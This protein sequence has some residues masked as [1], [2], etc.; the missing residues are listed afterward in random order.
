MGIGEGRVLVLGAALG[1]V[2]P[3]A[4]RGGGG[5]AGSG[6]GGILNGEQWGE[7]WAVAPDLC[8]RSGRDREARFFPSGCGFLY[9]IFLK[10]RQDRAEMWG[11]R[12]PISLQRPED[13]GEA[14][15]ESAVWL[16]PFSGAGSGP[17]GGRTALAFLLPLSAPCTHS[18]HS[19]GV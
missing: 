4:R 2:C 6:S 14:H 9:L 10:A 3:S 7:S 19:S 5:A 11:K 17:K 15:S 13:A 18:A 8:K 16:L 12:T 1:P